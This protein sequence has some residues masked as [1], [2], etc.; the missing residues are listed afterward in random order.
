MTPLANGE[1][2]TTWRRVPADDGGAVSRPA[3]TPDELGALAAR[4]IAPGSEFIT[5]SDC[6]TAALSLLPYSARY[7]QRSKSANHPS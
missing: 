2:T 6:L 7:R 1:L 5:G 4:L 3:G